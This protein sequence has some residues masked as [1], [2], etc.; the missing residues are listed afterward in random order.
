[1]AESPEQAQASFMRDIAP[2][3]R[4]KADLSLWKQRPG[5]LEFAAVAEPPVRI[6]RGWQVE[7]QLLRRA[8]HEPRLLRFGPRIHVVFE[9]DAIGTR[10]T[11]TG[12]CEREFCDALELLGAPGRWPA[13]EGRERD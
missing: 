1:M 11:I 7:H 3:L 9:T 13:V 8:R 12:R 6:G 4:R 10:V 5:A 2:E